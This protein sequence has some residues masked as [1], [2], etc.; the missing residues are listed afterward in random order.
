[1][2]SSV[3]AE[4]VVKPPHKP[5]IKNNFQVSL[6]EKDLKLIPQKM[7]ISKQPVAFTAKVP[8]GKEEGYQDRNHFW[9]R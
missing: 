1:M 8:H 3:N 2:P 4:N 6:A 7:P 9:H 5:V